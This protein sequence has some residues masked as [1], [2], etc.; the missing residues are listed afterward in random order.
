MDSGD[1]QPRSHDDAPDAESSA[2]G[3]SRRG[4]LQAAGA[5]AALAPVAVSAQ[6]AEPRSSAGTTPATVRSKT[7]RTVRLRVNGSVRELVVEPRV[8]LLDALRERARAH[9][10]QEGLR[11]RP[12]RRVHGAGRRP[13]RQLVPDAGGDARG[14]RDHDDRG[15]RHARFAASDAGR[16]H[17]PRRLPVRLLHARSDLLGGRAR[18]RAEGRHPQHRDLRRG[19]GRHAAAAHDPPSATPRSASA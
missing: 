10:H 11:P 15:P 5:T 4:F 3:L 14:Q 7:E 6:P 18:R 12:V 19:A 16:V 8:T 9:R 17:R 1:P 13:P 2:A